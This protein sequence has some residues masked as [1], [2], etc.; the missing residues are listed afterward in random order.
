MSQVPM[1]PISK[2]NELNLGGYAQA[3]RTQQQNY[4]ET[5]LYG[6]PEK[7]VAT[8]IVWS[9]GGVHVGVIGSWDNWQVRCGIFV[10]LVSQQRRN[11]WLSALR[12][13][14]CHFSLCVTRF[15][16]PPLFICW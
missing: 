16:S 14:N 6:E 5:C 11:R 7:E 15:V 4:Y 3:K 10:P 1:V 9:H 12:S 2:P 13:K 8:M